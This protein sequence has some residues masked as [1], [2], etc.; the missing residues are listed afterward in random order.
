MSFA[1]PLGLLGLL[2]VPPIVALHMFSKRARRHIISSLDLWDFAEVEVRG[3]KFHPIP[4]TLLMVI[5]VLIAIAL[6][7]ALSQPQIHADLAEGRARHMTVLLD[8]SISMTATDLTPD[9]FFHARLEAMN[10][11]RGLGPKDVGTVFTFGARP[12]RVGDT[13]DTDLP[14]LINRVASLQA[15]GTGQSLRQALALA[16][17][18]VEPGLPAEIHILSDASFRD[19]AIDALPHPTQVEV[20]GSS[21][22]NAAVID[23][24]V[25]TFG[26][27]ETHVFARFINFGHDSAQRLATLLADGNPIDSSPVTI[28]PESELTQVWSI[29]G[30]PASIA[31]ELVGEDALEADDRATRGLPPERA[32][33]AGLVT[34]SPS[35][36]DRALGAISA[37][38][39][40]IISPD[41]YLPGLDFDLTIF[42]HYL[43]EEWPSGLVFVIDPPIETDLLT[44][45]GPTKVIEPPIPLKDPLLTGVDFSGVRWAGKWS[46]EDFPEEYD[47]LMRSGEEPLM[48]RWVEG[49]S[50]ITLFLTQTDDGN[51]A[52]HPAFPIMIANIA[53]AARGPIIEGQILAGEPI[54]L[55]SYLQYPSMRIFPPD[56]ETIQLTRDRP[57]EWRDTNLPG[58][59]GLELTD[60]DGRTIALTLGANVGTREEADILPRGWEIS[61]DQSTTAVDSE[62]GAAINLTPWLLGAAALLL[63]LEAGLAW[64]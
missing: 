41:D 17:A 57:S 54:P 11:L 1:F 64:R 33:Q 38:D 22:Q 44:L 36:I 29:S 60:P 32:V 35:P 6:A 62:A 48:I 56:G 53:Q 9:R 8:D 5:D 63:L 15:G 21:S 16:L 45:S 23:L 10:L 12:E 46:L 40:E 55:P 47:V 18:G 39:F 61:A 52:E 34:S 37:V 14:E 25:R 59:Y 27:S 42:R 43:P 3:Q 30:R 20:Y 31:V 7:L 19:P 13:R 49:G 4:P 26:G 50:R 2:T 28:P 24:S 51:F 58:Y